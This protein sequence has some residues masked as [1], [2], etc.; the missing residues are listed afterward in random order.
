MVGLA[1]RTYF[2]RMTCKPIDSGAIIPAE[3]HH[4]VTSLPMDWRDHTAASCAGTFHFLTL[5]EARRSHSSF[6]N[7]VQSCDWI[8]W[9]DV[10]QQLP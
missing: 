2:P 4:A 7:L 8:C 6:K 3:L 5:N 10:R 9:P 1:A